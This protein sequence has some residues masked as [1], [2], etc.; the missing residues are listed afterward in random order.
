[1]IPI[2]MGTSKRN[3]QVFSFMIFTCRYFVKNLL[4][5]P[6]ENVKFPKK[7]NDRNFI[8]YLLVKS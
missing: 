2:V 5:D 3:M 8:A 7:K 1:M 6:A 4:D